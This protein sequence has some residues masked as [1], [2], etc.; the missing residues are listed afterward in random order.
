M[1]TKE[2]V[3]NVANI[4]KLKF[5]EDE[6]QEFTKKFGQVIGFVEKIKEVDTRG[7]EPTYTINDDN[8][9]M[10]DKG[11]SQTLTK[12]EVLQNAHQ[13]QYGYFKILKVV[14]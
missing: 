11:E 5:T 8:G 7:I 9:M 6:L 2:D 4:S 13:T 12:D 14:E 3:I 10:K 1:I